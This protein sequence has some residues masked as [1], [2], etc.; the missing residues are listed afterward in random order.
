MNFIYQIIRNLFKSSESKSEDSKNL[1]DN[2]EYQ[3]SFRDNEKD[4]G[5]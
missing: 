2:S 1:D 3:A 5:W 4:Q